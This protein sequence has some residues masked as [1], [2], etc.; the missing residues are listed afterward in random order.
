MPSS[1]PEQVAGDSA[2]PAAAKGTSARPGAARVVT[3]FGASRIG[4]GTP[5]YDAAYEVGRLLG[6]HGFTIC[7]GGYDGTMEAAARGA[8]DG[9]G[10]TIGVLVR[11]LEGRQHNV[12]LDRVEHTETLLLRLEKLVTLG[13][14]FI[15]LPGGIG[16]L[17]EFTLFWNLGQF[18]ALNK[19]IV[20]MGERWQGA[21]QGISEHLFIRDGDLAVFQVVDTPQEAVAAIVASLNGAN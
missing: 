17:L 14:A 19:P 18:G 9:G 15:V 16:T 21:L 3:L 10:Q 2:A 11:A 5:E 6:E 1:Q 12:W 13:E 4:P 8:K 7:N 20:V